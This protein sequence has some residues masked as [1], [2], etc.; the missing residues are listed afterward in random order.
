MLMT[1]TN[2]FEAK[3]IFTTLYIPVA[4]LAFLLSLPLTSH[5]PL[6]KERCAYTYLHTYVCMTV[7]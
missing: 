5:N 6:L 3:V 1:L 4:G 2:I 7:C